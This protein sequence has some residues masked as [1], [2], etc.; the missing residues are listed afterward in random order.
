MLLAAA[1]VTSGAPWESW[2]QGATTG[3][4][5]VTDVK[6][7]TEYV[8]QCSQGAYKYELCVPT[9]V[10]KCEPSERETCKYEYRTAYEEVCREEAV[11]V[12]DKIWKED[13]YGGQSWTNEHNPD[14][15]DLDQRQ[16]EFITR[17]AGLLACQNGKCA[18]DHSRKYYEDDS[19]NCKWLKDTKCT[20]Q[21]KKKRERV[22]NLETFQDCYTV[23]GQ[24]KCT[25]N[26]PSTYIEWTKQTC[27]A[28][29]R[30]N[31]NDVVGAWC[32]P[33]HTASTSCTTV[34]RSVPYTESRQVCS[35]TQLWH[36]TTVPVYP[37]SPTVPLYVIR[38]DNLDFCANLDVEDAEEYE[39][40]C[41]VVCQPTTVKECAKVTSGETD[42]EGRE[43]WEEDP[44]SCVEVEKTECRVQEIPVEEEEEGEVK[45]IPLEEVET[46]TTTTTASTTEE[47]CKKIWKD[48]GYGGQVFVCE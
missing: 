26:D 20:K 34:R 47:D 29:L 38:G 32:K 35:Q 19:S 14:Y 41:E 45:V 39:D 37:W 11:K 33:L 42:E 10:K 7:R 15:D 27:Q 24:I 9:K 46:T 21:P 3:C 16:D 12:C 8:N 1:A 31:Y 48:D 30:A 17:A 28:K 18:N 36:V 23:P 25:T 22:C 4:K 13:G 44:E 43:I 6:Y 40:I 2:G 5:T